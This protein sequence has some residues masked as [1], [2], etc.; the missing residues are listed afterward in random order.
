LQRAVGQLLLYEKLLDASHLKVLV[1]PQSEKSTDRLKTA[2]AKLDIHVLPYSQNGRTVRFE[3]T[4]LAR[5]IRHAK[6][7]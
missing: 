2:L 3:V 7:P 5:F 6:G 4:S 1:Y